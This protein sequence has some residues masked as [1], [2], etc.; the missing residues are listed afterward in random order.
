MEQG[1]FGIGSDWNER[2][3]A[4]VRGT[5]DGRESLQR[6]GAGHGQSKAGWFLDAKPRPGG[7][8]CVGRVVVNH[9]GSLTVPSSHS[10]RPR[11]CERGL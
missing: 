9:L 5:E 1:S 2:H 10:T 8:V 4:E 3:G 6:S 7:E 11:C